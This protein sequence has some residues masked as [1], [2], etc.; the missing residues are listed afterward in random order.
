MHC[1]R[2]EG[3]VFLLFLRGLLNSY[4]FYVA[5][6]ISLSWLL[7]N[8]IAIQYAFS[9]V[10][11]GFEFQKICTS[12]ELLYVSWNYHKMG[13]QFS[14]FCNLDCNRFCCSNTLEHSPDL[15]QLFCR[16]NEYHATPSG[17]RTVQLLVRYSYS[18][19]AIFSE[20]F[21]VTIHT[22]TVCFY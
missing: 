22:R 12:T 20:K 9:V 11:M 18:Y 10:G 13:S 21:G 14:S 6:D 15:D 1:C 3:F 5:I 7:E 19:I 17:S 4:Q 16:S 8:R 2:N